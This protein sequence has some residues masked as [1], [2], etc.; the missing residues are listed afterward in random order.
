MTTAWIFCL[1]T[2]LGLSTPNS[3]ALDRDLVAYWPLAGDFRDHSGN[4]L[5]AE[6]E[7]NV[8]LQA[9]G[10]DGKPGHAA[11]FD[12]HGGGL[13]V[14]SHPSL[15]L[16]D[17]DVTLSAWVFTEGDIDTP[18]GDLISRYDRAAR[19]GLMLGIKTNA[20][21]TFS[22]ANHRHLQFGIDD[23][24]ESDW[25]PVGVPGGDGTLLAFALASHDGALYA[26]TCEP[27]ADDSGHV[28]RYEGGSEWVDCGAP[29][30]SNS[31]TSLAVFE[32]N[33][34]AGTGRYRVAG[35]S[36]PESPND[37]PGGRVFRYEG[38][39][40]WTDC[41]PLPGSIAVSGLVVFQGKLY[42]GSLYAPAGFFRYDGGTT[43]TALETPDGKRVEAIAPF[44]GFLYATSYDRGHVYRFDGQTW[45]D[46]G[47]LGD[48]E[49]NTQT[50]SL[51]VYQ[52]SLHVGTW[53]SGR[54]YRLGE[55]G[56]WVDV[57]RLGEELEVMGMLPHN[58]RLMAGSLPLA[59]VYRYEGGQDWRLLTQLDTTPDVVYRRA[60]TMAEHAGRLFVS[61]LPSGQV[62][63]YRAG[64]MT[65]WNQTFP[66][67]WHHVAAVRSGETLRLFVDG[68]PVASETIDGSGA[69][70][71]S[72][73]VPLRIGSG[74]N[75]PFR[76]R[77][78]EVRLHRR[79]LAEEEIERLA[80]P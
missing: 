25:S 9:P 16:G 67:G 1:L 31:V 44:D 12:G 54:V 17:E 77:L 72:T 11:E 8:D 6:A 33:L 43:W 2:A 13:V 40:T 4:G 36:L 49:I 79:A 28:Y 45:T 69:F 15:D 27:G 50:Y 19:R 46:L 7:G 37:T 29:D 71:L 63:A 34:Y 52:G 23:D 42:A 60:W 21:V 32:G 41:G 62:F 20:G 24:R 39:T 66:D 76:G 26:G 57:G 58:G 59:Q 38:G 48:P 64:A 5:H 18:I 14:P 35:S 61:T 51:A 78:A 30:G 74:P 55:R 65:S 73:E 22:Q 10:R 75:A 53:R 68:R 47:A 80:S 56:D 70:D 3:D